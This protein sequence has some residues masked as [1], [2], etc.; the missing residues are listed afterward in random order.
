MNFLIEKKLLPLIFG[1]GS[2]GLP[3]IDSFQDMILGV[4]GGPSCL[5]GS[6]A[7]QITNCCESFYNDVSPQLNLG[8]FLDNLIQP[9]C[10]QLVPTVTNELT[11][12]LTPLTGPMSLG[13]PDETPCEVSD[14]NNNLWM[15]HM[16]SPT[17]RCSWDAEFLLTGETFTPDASFYGTKPSDL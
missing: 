7:D 13:T 6:P 16:G 4:M 15:D 12:L 8:T 5:V 17:S 11:G 10:V 3:K 9:L 2:N 14:W 1:D